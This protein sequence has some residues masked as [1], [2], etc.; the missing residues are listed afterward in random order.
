M[1]SLAQTRDLLGPDAPESD[2][3]V[4]A[5][6]DV[7]SGLA[8]LFLDSLQSKAPAEDAEAN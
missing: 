6:R 5:L 8:E 3:E 7:L 2:A 4:L 1:I